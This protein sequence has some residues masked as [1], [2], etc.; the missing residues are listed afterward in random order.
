MSKNDPPPISDDTSAADEPTAMW[1]ADALKDLGLEEAAK[2]HVETK[3][4]KPLAAPVTTPIAKARPKPVPKRNK[5]PAG[6]SISLPV[7]VAIAVA[8][9][10]GV[11]FLVTI[12]LG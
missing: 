3:D 7:L 9:G 4:A 12:A 2:S 6:S 1:D 10:I 11:Y 5:P 8:L